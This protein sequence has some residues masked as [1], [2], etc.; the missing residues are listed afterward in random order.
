M[1][2][3]SRTSIAL[4]LRGDELRPGEISAALGCQPDLSAPKDGACRSHPNQASERISKTGMWHKRVA[5]R[6]PGD[7]DGQIVELFASMTGDLAVWQRLTT[8]FHADVFCGLFLDEANQGIELRPE[9]LIALGARGLKLSLDVYG[10][11][12]D[13]G[14]AVDP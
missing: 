10:L 7:L 13:Q 4:R 9:T 14:F 1:A 12:E 8:R 6:S 3:I 11:R 5:R 2:V